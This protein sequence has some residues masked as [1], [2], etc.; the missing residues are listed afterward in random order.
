MTKTKPQSPE[1]SVTVAFAELGRL[2]RERAEFAANKQ[3]AREQL[4]RQ[5]RD[6]ANLRERFEAERPRALDRIRRERQRRE[7]FREQ[8]AARLIAEAESAHDERLAL[9]RAELEAK[10]LRLAALEVSSAVPAPRRRWLEWS[11]PVAATAMVAFLGMTLLDEEQA[12]AQ[13]AEV[14]VVEREAVEPANE[15]EIEDA[16]PAPEP[17]AESK[18]EPKPE[19]P[20]P[21]EPKPE[22]SK[23]KS[24]KSKSTK[25]KKSEE[26][27][28]TESK[29]VIKK[30][31]K[32]LE[33]GDFDGN[34]LG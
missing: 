14:Q 34:P 27:P 33:L 15:P 19:E 22:P 13:P 31:S 20:K 21:E 9:I 7:R 30:N 8:L 18:P 32:P 26:Q 25:S 29:P 3:S 6:L 28:K 5:A 12:V 4:A 10:R 2:E 11:V 24:T 16:A 17:V 1:C 23:K